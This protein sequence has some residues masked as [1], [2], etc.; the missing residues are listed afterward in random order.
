MHVGSHM[1]TTHKQS[2][3]LETPAGGAHIAPSSSL[4]IASFSI[5]YSKDI[6][7]GSSLGRSRISLDNSTKSSP[8]LGSSSQASPGLRILINGALKEPCPWPVRGVLGVITWPQGPVFSSI[9][10]LE[11]S[12]P[13]AKVVS[14]RDRAAKE[15]FRGA[16][17]VVRGATEAFRGVKGAKIGA[18]GPKVLSSKG[19]VG[20]WR[21]VRR[22]P[23][24]LSSTTKRIF[25]KYQKTKGDCKTS[26]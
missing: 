24:A 15:V 22:C 16:K 2:Q 5:R 10:V 25:L 18:K 17:V 7:V 8:D 9:Q 11:S 23:T 19:P 4:E 12:S 6:L 26:K 21:I 20:T 3:T 13:R 1:Q 14:G